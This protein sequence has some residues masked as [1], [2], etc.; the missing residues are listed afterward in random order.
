MSVCPMKMLR[1]VERQICLYNEHGPNDIG[2]PRAYLDAA[3]IAIAQG[4]LARGRIFAERAVSGWK[5]DFGEDNAQVSQYQKLA[6]DPSTLKPLYGISMKWKT[7]VEDVPSGLEPTDFED[8]LWKREKPNP[9]EVQLANLRN[10]ETFPG[11]LGIPDEHS[12]DL[13]PDSKVFK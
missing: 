11:F 9:A 8:W 12:F 13:A 10:P 6:R 3:Q 5:M 1:Y 7:A 4:D 2:L